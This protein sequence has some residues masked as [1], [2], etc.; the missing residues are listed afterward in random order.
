MKRIFLLLT[1]IGGLVSC[2]QQRRQSAMLFR[3]INPKDF[4]A[5]S[6]SVL[7]LKEGKAIKIQVPE[8][9]ENHYVMMRELFDT[10][11]AVPLETTDSSLIGVIDKI[12]VYDNCIYV[13]DRYK[14]KSLKRFSLDGKY[15]NAVGRWGE[16][17]DY[18][19]EPTDFCISEGEIFLLDQ[20]QGK[21]FRYSPDGLLNSS[22]RIPFFCTEFYRFGENSYVFHG[23]DADNYHFPE[24]L[25]Y[26]LWQTDSNFVVHTMSMYR[27]KDKYIPYLQKNTLA[28][29][30][31]SVY[32]RKSLGDTIYSL[33]PDGEV[34]CDYILDFQDKAMPQRLLE[35]E[36]ER[37]FDKEAN[38]RSNYAF[39]DGYAITPDYIYA[40]CSLN[41]LVYH[42]FYNLSSCKVWLASV[43]PND[44][45]YFF[46][47]RIPVGAVDNTLIGYV[48]A[49]EIYED[50]HKV[51][52]KAWAEIPEK[53]R[54]EIF[55][56]CE[57]LKMEDN[58]IVLFYVLK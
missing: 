1:L 26:S 56:T 50:F 52:E 38:E 20:F 8:F 53:K 58:P 24:I 17:P 4:V 23:V 11:Y 57:N 47:F 13:L 14:T 7:G 45:N 34:F 16:G 48:Q 22:V 46:P 21:I 31:G 37:E 41:K 39:M 6:L 9:D 27:K 43:F 2:F 18:Y 25:D 51:S 35:K 29:Y 19:W 15:L 12:V 3:D 54:R 5:D 32:Y 42:L 33:T 10:V 49:Y 44:I 28:C 36:N 40:N 55:A 30:N